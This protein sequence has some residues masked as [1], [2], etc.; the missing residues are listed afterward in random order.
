MYDKVFKRVEEKYIISKKQM[1]LI[2]DKFKDK[3]EKDKY[4][5]ST[6][7]NIYFDTKDNDLIIKSIDKPIYKQKIR[8]RSYNTPKM[9]DEVFLEIKSKYKG[10]V[11]KRRNKMSLKEYYDYLNKNK[12]DEDNQIMK[13]INY[14]FQLYKLKPAIYI[15]YD[16]NSYKG[17]F[18]DNLRITFDSNLRSRREDLKL[19]LGSSGKKYFTEDMY[20]MEI[21]C[22][23]AMPLWLVNYLSEL[24]VYPKSFSKYGNIYIKEILKL[25]EELI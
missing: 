19:E 1:D 5:E 13:E 10:M 18:D 16:R 14:F 7:C 25:R 23:N 4:F 8:L 24:R 21:K 2:L 3:I 11:G 20:I 9:K 15:A 22:L 6:I 12:F 17:I